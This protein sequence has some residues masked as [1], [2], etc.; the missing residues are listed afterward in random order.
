MLIVISPAK[1]LELGLDLPK[2]SPATTEP[3]LLDHSEKLIAAARKLSVK[4]LMELMDISQALAELNQERYHEWSPDHAPEAAQ[5]ALMVFRGNVYQGLNAE[6][7]EPATVKRAQEQLRI[8]SG[9][10]GVLRPL[11]RIRPYRL[12]MGRALKIGRANS[13]YEYWGATIAELLNADL[14]AAGTT[15]L[16]NLASEEYFKSVQTKALTPGTQVITP[17]FLDEVK[18]GFRPMGFFAKRARGL[19]ARYVLE[20]PGI[21]TEE[22]LTKFDVEGYKFA[23][24]ESK[25]GHPVFTRR[26]KDRPAVSLPRAL[27]KTPMEKAKKSISTAA[28]KPKAAAKP[29]KKS[30]TA[31]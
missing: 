7:W 20:H 6:S 1:N 11:D 24:A 23:K 16:L 4:K 26:E 2:G 13:I 3:R 17:L 29:R 5:P 22:A 27:R 18:S 15:T 12:E 28:A 10:Y 8:L 21:E 31:A 14:K 9:L 30:A 25:P 19:L